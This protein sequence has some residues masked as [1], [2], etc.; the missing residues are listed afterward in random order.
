[1]KRLTLTSEQD[2]VVKRLISIYVDSENSNEMDR[3]LLI[4]HYVN[5]KNGWMNK[6]INKFFNTISLTDLI[7]IIYEGY[8]VDKSPEE[9]LFSYYNALDARQKQIII[10]TLNILNIKVEGIN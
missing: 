1:M 4:K 3:E 6:D 7:S 10:N 8:D 2:K 5:D 9:E